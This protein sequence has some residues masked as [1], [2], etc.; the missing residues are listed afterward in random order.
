MLL[1][2]SQNITQ[3]HCGSV[4]PLQHCSKRYSHQFLRKYE[5]QDQ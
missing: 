3:E 5:G 4:I 1:L 2:R